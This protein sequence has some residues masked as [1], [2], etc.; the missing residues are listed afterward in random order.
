MSYMRGVKFGNV[1]NTRL[2]RSYGA[3]SGPLR[4][5]YPKGYAH[6][7][8]VKDGK[9][10]PALAE[11]ME[12]DGKPAKVSL[13]RPGRKMG[14]KAGK[15]GKGKTNV[16]VVVMG[17]PPGGPGMPGAG[18]PMPMP[19]P[20]AGGPPMPPPPM[21]SPPMP[22]PGGPPMGPPPP[23]GMPMRKHGGAVGRFAKGGKVKVGADP[24]HEKNT[25]DEDGGWNGEK[26]GGKYAKGGS[27]KKDFQLDNE[28][29]GSVG[30]KAREAKIKGYG[31]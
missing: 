18:G 17:H 2:Q 5:T 24:I 12:A 28:D 25:D 31:K 3:G 9:D 6:G 15:D 19:P 13:A 21:A 8:A 10:G 30:A 1:G 7:G 23:A 29:G 11:G 20:G 27:V 14:G 4:D 22:P 26:K 16:N